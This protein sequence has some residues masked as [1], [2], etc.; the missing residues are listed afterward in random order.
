VAKGGTTFRN[1]I[2]IVPNTPR[3]FTVSNMDSAPMGDYQ[4]CISFVPHI[5]NSGLVGDSYARPQRV[6]GNTFAILRTEANKGAFPQTV[7]EGP[8]TSVLFE[9]NLTYAP[10]V[11]T[12]I[13]PVAMDTTT[14]GFNA[15]HQGMRKGFERVTGSIPAG[16]V[17]N[18]A[19]FSVPYP[20]DMRGV[21][22][23][24]ANYSG[25][26]NRHSL[27]LNGG[28][29]FGAIPGDTPGMQMDSMSVSFG[30]TSITVTNRSG[31]TWA[32]G[33]SFTLRL[34]RGTTLMPVWPLTAVPAG[35]LARYRPAAPLLAATA[36][37]PVDDFSG[38]Q[39]AG[40][41]SVGAW[42]HA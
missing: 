33:A 42:Q 39:R 4:A 13:V 40:S 14:L 1:N 21:A 3:N 10:N 36:P 19:S 8:Y 37:V 27:T 31:T 18:G 30:A 29:R 35:T 15:V 2:L 34:D 11:A 12:P 26:L 41:I 24:Q 16:G 7:D 17:A 9:N 32:G 23:V 38:V 6:Y 20:G 22:T 28:T 25:T 5:L